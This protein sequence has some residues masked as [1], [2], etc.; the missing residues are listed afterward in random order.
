[1]NDD[2]KREYLKINVIKPLEAFDEL[3]D[4][5]T[6]ENFANIINFELNPI[7]E[8][9]ELPVIEERDEIEINV[10]KFV[11]VGKYGGNGRLRYDE[12]IEMNQEIRLTKLE[13]LDKLD[14][15]LE[16]SVL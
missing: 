13:K 14:Q 7:S 12:R 3:G 16:D 4:D 5:I 2:E 6:T 15:L 10:N 9:P 1:M 11:E 8:I